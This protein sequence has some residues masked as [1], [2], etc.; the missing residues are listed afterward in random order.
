MQFE[1]IH[2]FPQLASNL[3]NTADLVTE[4]NECNW[5]IL[6]VLQCHVSCAAVS[7]YLCCSVVL[8]TLK[9]ECLI[10]LLSDMNFCK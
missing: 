7:Y 4:N 5:V 6:A 9:V 2:Q 8:F 1:Y 3:P 10:L